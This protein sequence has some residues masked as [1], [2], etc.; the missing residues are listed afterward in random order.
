MLKHL[1]NLIIF[2]D[3][4]MKIQFKWVVINLFHSI[5]GSFGLEGTSGNQQLKGVVFYMHKG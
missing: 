2:F 5:I 3:S 1:F 4:Y